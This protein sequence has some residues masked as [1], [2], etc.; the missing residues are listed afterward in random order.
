M[1][2]SDLCD[3]VCSDGSASK[4]GKRKTV[5]WAQTSTGAASAAAT[6][7]GAEGQGRPQPLGQ[8]NG[9]QQRQQQQQQQPPRCGPTS[10]DTQSRRLLLKETTA[11][12]GSWCRRDIWHG[13]GL[14]PMDFTALTR[15]HT[16]LNAFSKGD[17]ADYMREGYTQVTL[18]H[19]WGA[20]RRMARRLT[21]NK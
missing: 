8:L 11:R 3:S 20:G 1:L 12:C 4:R 5:Q 9:I 13:I 16:V 15:G 19:V 7:G 10:G 21:M 18:R 2:D 17:K 14:C 6:G